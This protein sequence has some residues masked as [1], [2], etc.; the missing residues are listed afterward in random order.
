MF[1]EGDAAKVG[2]TP[3]TATGSV[4]ETPTP[5]PDGDASGRHRHRR[6]ARPRPRRPPTG[7]R[8][9]P[10]LQDP[11]RARR[12]GRSPAAGTGRWSSRPSA[13]QAA[14]L[15]ERIAVAQ[16]Q[17]AQSQA[18]VNTYRGAQKN[19]K[20]NY[21]TVVRLGKAVPTDDDTR[22][23]L[24]QLDTSAKRAGA[25]FDTINVNGG[26]VPTTERHPRRS[27]RGQRR[28]VLRDAVL[29]SASPARSPPSA[30]S[31]RGSSGSSRSR[32][33]RSPST[34]AW[35]ASR[36]SRSLPA[37]DGLARPGRADRRQR[38]HRARDHRCRRGRCRRRHH[39][40]VDH[41][42]DHHDDR[43][44]RRPGGTEIR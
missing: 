33:T 25:D 16:A 14:D 18:L 13:P 44:D 12:G 35:C 31:S 22:S 6:R 4:S 41:D 10:Y 27:G 7:R 43:L 29:A 30:T 3:V 5:T 42:H 40:H 24:V 23:L 19:Y 17:L 20:A 15:Q 38:L 9:E 11:A 39:G 34:G 36:A 21:E 2:I 1:F 28:R 32:A 37:E 26:G 8:S